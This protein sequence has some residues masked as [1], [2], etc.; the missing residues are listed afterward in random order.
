[1]ADSDLRAWSMAMSVRTTHVG[2]HVALRSFRSKFEAAVAVPV[3]FALLLA[4]GCSVD[5]RCGIGN[6]AEAFE[7]LVAPVKYLGGFVAYGRCCV[8]GGEVVFDSLDR[9]G[10]L[11]VVVFEVADVLC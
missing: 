9:G 6:V 3:G 2:R 11:R 1:V 10:R 5:L 8:G 4:V 7:D